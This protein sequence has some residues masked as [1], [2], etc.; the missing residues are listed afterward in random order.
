M[1]DDSRNSL[2]HMSWQ[3]QWQVEWIYFHIN[4]QQSLIFLQIYYRS[5]YTASEF[6]LLVFKHDVFRQL[7]TN[8]ML[9]FDWSIYI[10]TGR[11]DG[12]PVPTTRVDGPCWQ[13]ELHDNAFF[14]SGRQ[15]GLCTRLTGAHYAC[16]RAG[17]SGRVYG[18]IFHHQSIHGPSARPVNSARQHE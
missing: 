9:N 6:C 15:H 8:Q 3:W 18:C 14:C 7:R 2:A 1:V 17:R 16:W 4:E 13:K 12:C 5:G 10:N 11:A